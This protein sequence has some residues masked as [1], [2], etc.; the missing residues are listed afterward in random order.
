VLFIRGATLPGR[1]RV[2]AGA[3][4]DGNLGTLGDLDATRGADRG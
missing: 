1:E 4:G 2:P 3:A